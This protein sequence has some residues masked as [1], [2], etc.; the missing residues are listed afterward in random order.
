MTELTVCVAAL[1]YKRPELL[2]NLLEILVQQDI[3]V[4]VKEIQFLIVDND[5]EG[6]A[7]SV[8]ESFRQSSPGVNILY[9]VEP[10][11]GIPAGRNRAMD[12]AHSAG[13]NILC[14]TDDDARPA[15]GWLRHLVGCFDDQHPAMV[16][17]PAR[18]E[19]LQQATG[20][21]SNFLSRSLIA[22]SEFAEKYA[23]RQARK[24]ICHT[25]GTGNCLLNL[26]WVRERGIRFSA[27]MTESGGSDTIFREAVR[28]EGGVIRWC[29]QAIVHEQ[30]PI[31]RVSLRYQFSRARAHG[32]TFVK[33]GRKA[34]QP[35][36]RSP[37]GRIVIGSML[38]IVP[39]VGIASFVL[40]VQ[41]VGMGVGMI[42]AKRGAS[43][44]LYARD[45]NS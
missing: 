38:V 20:F 27:D 12:E 22:K 10:E 11:P 9:V 4:A 13:A 6:S 36:L 41:L 29:E 19:M 43:G 17:G 26:D 28:R 21:W 7:R 18:F 5:P 1:T 23:A 44:N 3:D 30:L 15:D 45:R 31:E 39:F 34:S 14:F 2:R 16:F 37:A 33:S 42:Q 25:G 8:V 40:G 24:G 35:V 32:M